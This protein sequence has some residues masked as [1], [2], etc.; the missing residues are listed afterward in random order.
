MVINFI[1]L[2]PSP[3][4]RQEF[5]ILVVTVADQCFTQLRTPSIFRVISR[6]LNSCSCLMS[7]FVSLHGVEAGQATVIVGILKNNIA[8]FLRE[9][10]RIYA[11]VA[12][13]IYSNHVIVQSDSSAQ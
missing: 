13:I 11:M 3:L 6:F 5:K 2:N 4:R 1:F 12:T 9:I 8:T 7:R 10:R